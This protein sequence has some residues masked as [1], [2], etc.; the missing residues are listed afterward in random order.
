MAG[1]L[2]TSLAVS[3][4]TAAEWVRTAHALEG[5][6]AISAAY[7]E[8]RLSADQ[9]VAV[10]EAATPETEESLL[11]ETE[12]RTVAWIQAA[13]R[14]AR[15]ARSESIDPASRVRSVRWWW[16]QDW[17][18]LSARLP[19]EDGAMVAKALERI[20]TEAGPDPATG[21]YGW[22]SMRHAD[23]LVELAA[24]RL[25]ADADPARATVVVH[26]DAAVLARGKGAADLEDGPPLPVAVARRLA[27]DARIE[28]VAEGPTGPL[29]VGRTRRS[30]P[31]WLSRHL[32]RRDQG[33]RFPGCG[34]TRHLQA[35]HIEH[36][37]E[38]GPT[39]AGNLCLVCTRHHR[40][41]HEE[42]WGLRGSPDGDLAFVRPDGR[43][44][45]CGPPPTREELRNR[46]ASWG[47]VTAN[48]S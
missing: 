18:R 9:V 42:G 31:P 17:M 14:H 2:Q 43:P 16:E 25:A 37:A 45:V 38:G 10:A 44:L 39:D 11:E 48:S 20:S 5:L 28:V 15:I 22:D 4:R 27:C 35:H 46:L 47:L 32:R 3:H 12:R 36:W 23:A 21:M 13:A 24:T 7:L 6:P 33:C 29:G 40:L 19:A 1:W 41:I 8:G 30:V 26:V 34:R